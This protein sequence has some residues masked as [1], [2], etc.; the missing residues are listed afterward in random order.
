MSGPFYLSSREYAGANPE[1]IR[2]VMDSLNQAE[3][4]TRSD[5]TG[6]V[7]IMARAPASL[8]T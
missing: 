6:S 4:L 3:A 7:A 1:F 2:Q 8:R 5:E